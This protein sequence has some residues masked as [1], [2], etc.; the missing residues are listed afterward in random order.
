MSTNTMP[1][2]AA[3]AG[4]IE[5]D[6]RGIDLRQVLG[7]LRARLAWLV[8][9]PLLVG[10]LVAGGTSFLTPVFT[11]TTTFMPP[12]QSANG[13]SSLLSSLGPLAALAGGAAASGGSADR[14]VSLMQSVTV[15]DRIIDQFKL[16][17]AYETKARIDTRKL[18]LGNVQISVGKKDGL[19]SV[20]VDDRSPQRAAEMA[21]Q[22]VVELRRLLGTLAVTEAQQR[23]VFFEQQLRQ[24]RDRL[25]EAQQ[26]LQASGFSAGALK[27]EPR[28]A[29]EAYAQL[30]AEATMAEVKLQTL[31]Q[32]RADTSAEVLKQQSEL[33][34]L[35]A[36][37]AR[38]EQPAD[39]AAGPDYVSKYREF[40]YQEA[41]FEV[42]ARQFELARVDESR[43]GTLIQVIDPALP[44]ERRSKP[45]RTLLTLGSTVATFLA[46]VAVLMLALIF[47]GRPGSARS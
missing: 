6:D 45:N 1:G 11:A 40:K 32:S 13:L 9:L 3:S 33:A 15:T 7:V 12:Q 2:A 21:N 39:K 26:A 25:A 38:S 42:Y 20:Q 41:L 28:A 4:A 29:A 37:L 35:R 36:Q 30:K 19:I 31:R 10:G 44:P 24:T 18:L 46:V 43:E 23:R 17:E 8:V 34:A 5:D 14:Y 27:T 22:Y 16:M 47:G